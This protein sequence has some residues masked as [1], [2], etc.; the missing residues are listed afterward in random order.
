MSPPTSAI[1]Q[2][3][4]SFSGGGLAWAAFTGGAL[5]YGFGAHATSGLSAW[6]AV[7][8]VIALMHFWYDGFIWSVR[9]GEV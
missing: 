5:A 6:Y 7:T 1:G 9:R 4:A 8:L 3:H 2:S